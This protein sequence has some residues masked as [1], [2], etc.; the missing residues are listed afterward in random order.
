VKY[1]GQRWVRITLRTMHLI[2]V[3]FVSAG[4][5]S[6]KGIHP[7]WLVG[8]VASG[9]GLILDDFIRYG[10]ALFRYLQFWVTILK[11]FTLSLALSYPAQATQLFILAIILGSFI[12]H[13]PGKIRQYALKGEPGPC[14]TKA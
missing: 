10:S 11:V 3:M 5:V 1:R 9:S 4:V 8:L 6:T 13:A 2:C 7:D 12:S 14:G